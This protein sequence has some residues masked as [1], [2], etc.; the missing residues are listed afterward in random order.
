M[1]VFDALAQTYVLLR[2]KTF[3]SPCHTLYNVKRSAEENK[4]IC[5]NLKNNIKVWK[6][7]TFGTQRGYDA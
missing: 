1:H 3:N 4:V 6:F 7:V 2:K 5:C